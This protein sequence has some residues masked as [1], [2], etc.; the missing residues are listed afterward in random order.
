MFPLE[1]RSLHAWLLAV[2][3][4]MLVSPGAAAQSPVANE[5]EVKAAFIYNFIRFVEWPAARFESA[6]A[7]YLVCVAGGNPFGTALDEVLADRT[8]GDRAIQTRS[9]AVIDPTAS[10]CHVTFVGA[11]ERDIAAAAANNHPGVLT[12]GEGI[13]FAEAGGIIALT[14][15]DRKVR[16]AINVKRAEMAGLRISSQLLRLAEIVEDSSAGSQFGDETH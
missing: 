4:W 15:A 9:I 12:V 10:A 6:D 8:A 13:G 1:R 5:Y 7:P 3:L 11:P 2:S 14:V 16:F